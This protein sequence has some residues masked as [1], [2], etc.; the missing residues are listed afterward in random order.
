[1]SEKYNLKYTGSEMDGLLDNANSLSGIIVMWSGAIDKI[2]TGWLLCDGTNGTPD[3]RNRFIVGAGTDYS[4]GNTG[5]SNNVV[6][7]TAQI[8]SHTHTATTTVTSNGAHTHSYTYYGR[9]SLTQRGTGSESYSQSTSSS[10]GTTGENGSHNHTA[11]TTLENVGSGNA[12][13]NRPPYYAL[14]YIMK[15]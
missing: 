15:V 8:P 10:K 3:L 4:V 6:L 7:T 14:A 9:G 5:G 2:P 12:H 1:M 11:T 13:E